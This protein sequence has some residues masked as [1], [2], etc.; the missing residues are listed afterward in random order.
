[1]QDL[2]AL[3]TNL[4]EQ[5]IQ[6]TGQLSVDIGQ[7][8]HDTL[9]EPLQK[10]SDTAERA[11]GDQSVN[12]ARMLGHL[13]SAFLAHMK[14]TMGCQLGD[15]SGLMQQTTHVVGQV[16]SMLR[17]TVAD[18]ERCSQASSSGTQA[19]V[20]GLIQSLSDHQSQLADI[21]ST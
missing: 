5:Q 18:I 2:K 3:L 1:M 9:Q 11:G 6:A 4:I 7:S 21:A 17:S 15:L 12:S 16:E 14:E 13:M 10:I 8:L 19:V 20:K